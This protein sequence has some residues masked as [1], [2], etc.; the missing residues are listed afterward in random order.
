MINPFAYLLAAIRAIILIILMALFLLI[1]VPLDLI[2]KI[3]TPERNFWLRRMYVRVANII[4]GIRCQVTGKAYEGT[5]LYLCN[6]RSLSDPLIFSAYIDAFVI[7]KAEVSKIPVLDTG[8]KVTGIIYVKRESQNSRHAV[9]EKMAETL[10]DGIN[11]LVYPEGTVNG[12]PE[13]LEYRPGT[14]IEAVKNNIPVV[15][16]VLEY[17]HDK[18]IWSDGTLVSH[19]FSQFG[20]LFTKTKL[21]IGPPMTADDGIELRDKIMTWSQ[22]QVYTAHKGWGSS[23]EKKISQQG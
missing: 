13:L 21:I 4:L 20:K 12:E 2:F 6:H 5:A 10:R 18:D 9:R 8:A 15:P 14:C 17:R 22:E 23:L 3:G 1:Y 16:V 19:F 7:A 11:I